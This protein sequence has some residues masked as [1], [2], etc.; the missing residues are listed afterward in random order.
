MREL[1]LNEVSMVSGGASN[2][3]GGSVTVGTGG[4]TIKSSTGGVYND[5]VNVYEGLV[6]SMSYVIERVAKSMR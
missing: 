2:D 6:D 4:I 3:C 5:I 1:T